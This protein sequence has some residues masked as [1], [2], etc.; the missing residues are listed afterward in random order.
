MPYLVFCKNKGTYF[1]CNFNKLQA[2]EE[3][4][5]NVKFLNTLERHL[6]LIAE[7]PSDSLKA[8]RSIQEALPPLMESLRLVWVLSSYF[9]QDDTMGKL[10]QQI[11]T[12]IGDLLFLPGKLATL[13][14]HCKRRWDERVVQAGKVLPFS[15][16]VSDS[17]RARKY[18]YSFLQWLNKDTD[19]AGN[20]CLLQV[21][22]IL[23]PEYI[24]T[25][26]LLFRL[27]W[28]LLCS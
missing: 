5:E 3:A 6:R 16:P 20:Y 17:D 21:E 26:I 22:G 13:L 7:P 23:N 4:K 9:S 24:P 14:I 1:N 19:F 15:C 18:G 28:Y 10:L 12:Q 8:F 27:D 2:T 11:G 25:L